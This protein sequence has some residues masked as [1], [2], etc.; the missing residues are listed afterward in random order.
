MRY[1]RYALSLF[2]LS[3]GTFISAQTAPNF[4]VTDSW[5]TT[6]RLYEDYL[7]QGK[8]VVIEIFFAACPPC[9]A[10]APYMEPL[11]QEWDAGQGDVQFIELSILQTDTDARVNIYKNNHSTTYPAAGGEGGSV[12]ASLPYKSGLFG[13]YTGTPTFVVVAPDGTVEFDIDGGNIPATIDALD[14]AIAATGAE[15]NSSATKE[16]KKVLPLT[17]N[18][19]VVTERLDLEYTGESTQL[20]TTLINLLGQVYTSA[21]FPMDQNTTQGINISGLNNG[22]WVLRVQDMKSN[23]MA[24]YLFLKQ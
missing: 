12:S 13:P 4:T 22:F 3:L 11:Y 7:N 18:C 1:Y 2:L 15:K 24:S 16:P 20:N 10:I 17:L 21:R 6:H 14:A 8:T 19:N 23:I 9:N 5:G